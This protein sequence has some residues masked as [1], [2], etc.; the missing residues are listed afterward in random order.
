VGDDD[1]GHLGVSQRGVDV[2][3]QRR[4]AHR[5]KA[6][7]GSLGCPEGLPSGQGGSEV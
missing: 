1:A 6:I 3:G 4:P 2:A 7:L 5:V